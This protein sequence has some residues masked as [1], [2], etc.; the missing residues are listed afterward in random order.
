MTTADH[1]IAQVLAA[2]PPTVPSRTQIA[3]EL[4]GHIA[5][6]LD[7]GMPLEG[8]LTQLGPPDQ[9]AQAYL[10]NTPMPAADFG[11]RAVAKVIDVAVV[12]GAACAP[13]LAVLAFV[14]AEARFF[15]VVAGLL[16]ASLGFPIY[17]IVAEWRTGQTIGKR[18]YGLYVVRES[19][20]PIGL[21]VAIV[22]QLGLLLQV[23]WIDAIFALFTTRRQR[24]FEMLSKSCVV[25]GPTPR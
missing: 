25:Q 22:R 14:P 9:L 13:A 6:R 23:F 15:A 21:G 7:A 2:L 24:A 16:A 4:R 11:A 3:D 1:Y 5:E 18:R 8:V 17:T 10:A 12:V 20:L 19:G